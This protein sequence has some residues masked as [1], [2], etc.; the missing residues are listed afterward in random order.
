MIG[1]P[2][3][4]I[5]TKALA[6]ALL[7]ALLHPRLAGWVENS[8]WRLLVLVFL[9]EVFDLSAVGVRER[10]AAGPQ[11]IKQVEGVRKSS[12]EMCPG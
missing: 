11:D 12:R 4:E 10:S 8:L 1:G 5:I 6:P 2:L 7:A 3:L 9:G